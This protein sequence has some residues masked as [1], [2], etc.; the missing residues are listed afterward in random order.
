MFMAAIPVSKLIASPLSAALIKVD[1]LGLAGWRWLLILEGALALV[2]EQE[3][4]WPQPASDA[5]VCTI[6]DSGMGGGH[7]WRREAF[8]LAIA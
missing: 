5:H 7:S 1:W 3:R 4:K 8:S 6:G 2:L